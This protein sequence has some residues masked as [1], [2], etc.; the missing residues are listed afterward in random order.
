MT[1]EPD[2]ADTPKLVLLKGT[3]ITAESLAAMYKELTGR[4][5]TPEGLEEMRAILAET[6]PGSETNLFRQ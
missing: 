4:E 6:T 5:V 1:T 3:E 2:D